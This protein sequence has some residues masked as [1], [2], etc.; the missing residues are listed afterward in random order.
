M[1]KDTLNT[2][3]QQ[4]YNRLFNRQ[5]TPLVVAYVVLVIAYTQIPE[6]IGAVRALM[7][8]L[9]VALIIVIGIVAAGKLRD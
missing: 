1:R 3:L 7:S 8:K 2:M 9:A 4:I 5:L 6:S